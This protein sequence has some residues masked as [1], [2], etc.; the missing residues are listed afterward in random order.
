M[1]KL[2]LYLTNNVFMF[3]P[4]ES[5]F[6]SRREGVLGRPMS[7][8]VS[9][10]VLT[11]KHVIYVRLHRWGRQMVIRLFFFLGPCN[12]ISLQ[13]LAKLTSFVRLPFYI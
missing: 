8:S 4:F 6:M 10:C 9:A 12:T 1:L 5:T 11:G 3:P 13:T 2:S 7:V